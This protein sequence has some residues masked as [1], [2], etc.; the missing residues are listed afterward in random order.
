MSTVTTLPPPART[1]TSD[2]AEE[3]VFLQ[4]LANTPAGAWLAD[5][6]REAWSRFQALPWPTRKTETWRFSSQPKLSLEGYRVAAADDTGPVEADSNLIDDAAGIIIHYN[7]AS[8]TVSLDPELAAQGVIFCPLTEAFEKHAALLRDTY[9]CFK[10]AVG[11]EKYLALHQAYAAGGVFIHVPSNVVIKRPLVVYHWVGGD[12]NALFPHSLI[13]AGRHAEVNVVEFFRTTNDTDAALILG[14]AE[15][16]AGDGAKVFRKTAQLI[17]EHSTFVQIENTQADRD[18]EVKQVALLLG[19]SRSRHENQIRINGAGAHVK[20]YSLAVADQHQ[21][22]DQRTLQVHSAPNGTSDLLYKNA[23]FDDS[24]TIFSGLI[25]VDPEG[26]QTDAYQ[27]NRNL[28]LSTTAE[29]NSLPGLEIEAND[30][31]CSHGA[32][33]GQVDPSE[34]FYMRSRG[35]PKNAAEELL[36]FGFFNEIIEKVDS[37][38][39]AETLRDLLRK[40]FNA[41]R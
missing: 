17:N 30:V 2:L 14:A 39:L 25:R 1:A 18:A 33:T 31:K 37:E 21:E 38:S 26:Q 27:T 11:G 10:E 15:V 7:H 13:V 24:R 9:G 32:T 16:H 20:V 6:K 41:R 22:I 29:A 8:R 36:V 23:L 34:L 28:L 4:H 3:S 12:Q 35:I 19:S 5:L 40:K